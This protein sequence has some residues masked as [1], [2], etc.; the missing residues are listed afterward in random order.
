MMIKYN[1]NINNDSVMVNLKRITNQ[2]Y[3]LLPNREEGIDWEKPLSTLIEELAGMNELLLNQHTILFCLLC[4]LEGL[5]F[6]NT[7]KPFLL[8]R[9]TIFECLGL[10]NDLVN[11]IK[12]KEV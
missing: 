6:L 2:I 10:M 1:I 9:R 12:L 4:K 3:K 7:E 8:F 5:F 11:N